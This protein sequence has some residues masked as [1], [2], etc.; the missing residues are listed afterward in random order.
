MAKTIEN[1]TDRKKLISTEVLPNSSTGLATVL[2]FHR[3]D[4][5]AEITRLDIA[6]L[7]DVTQLLIYGAKQICS[8]V[9]AGVDDAD[10]KCAGIAAAVA[11]LDAGTWPRRASAPATLEPAIA[12][13]MKA[14]GC[15]RAAARKLLG[16]LPE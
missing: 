4:T 1:K 15:D 14:Q 10:K 2:V 9:V 3:T 7:T 5:G 13:I 16:M 12:M 11:A 6:R 8:D